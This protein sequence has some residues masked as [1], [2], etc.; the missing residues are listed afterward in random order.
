VVVLREGVPA[1]EGA[2]DPFR[3]QAI[4]RI[5]IPINPSARRTFTY[6]GY[7]RGVRAQARDLVAWF[8]LRR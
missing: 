6:E 3:V 5:E 8:E 1:S 2:G 4:A 7:D